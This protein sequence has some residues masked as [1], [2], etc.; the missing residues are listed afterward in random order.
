VV[1]PKLNL[2][3]DFYTS[4][5]EVHSLTEP[6]YRA[7]QRC[8]IPKLN[9]QQDFYTSQVEVYSLTEPNYRA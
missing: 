2:K 7:L 9:L 6:N 5:V 8:R 3:Q 4:Q 1:I